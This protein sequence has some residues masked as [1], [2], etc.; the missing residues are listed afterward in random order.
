MAPANSTVALRQMMIGFWTSQAIYVA[1]KLGVADCLKDGPRTADEVAKAT[2][3]Q[4]E[5][6]YRLLRALASVGI[7]REDQ[8]RR[9]SM[10]PMAELLRSDAEDSQRPLA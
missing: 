7:F 2:G 6:L 10:T 8:Q 1:C 5:A 3:S 9:F 4:P